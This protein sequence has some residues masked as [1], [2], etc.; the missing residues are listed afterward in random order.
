MVTNIPIITHHTVHRVD[1]GSVVS[2][3]GCET[4]FFRNR[5]LSSENRLLA[6]H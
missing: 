4:R 1:A 6:N 3:T 5:S 2:D